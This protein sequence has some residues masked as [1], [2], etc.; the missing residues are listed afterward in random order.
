MHF[1]DILLLFQS[2]QQPCEVGTSPILQMRKLR[3]NRE[4][5]KMIQLVMA[6]FILLD[7]I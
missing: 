1:V 6:D 4:L 5:T 3:L 7:S 2:S